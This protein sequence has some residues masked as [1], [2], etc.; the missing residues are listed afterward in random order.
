MSV[1]WCSEQTFAGELSILSKKK[2]KIVFKAASGLF[3]IFSV[4][5][6]F[7]PYKYFEIQ[8]IESTSMFKKENI[9]TNNTNSKKYTLNILN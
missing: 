8:T 4:L 2:I 7:K 1:L 5:N 6:Y 9:R 3:K